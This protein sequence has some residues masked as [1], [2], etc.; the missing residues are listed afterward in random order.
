MRIRP[1]QH[2]LET[3][4]AVAEASFQDGEWSWGGRSGRNSISDAEQLLCIMAPA[5]KIPYFKIDVPDETAEDVL[6]SLRR[7]GDS[8]ELPRR[9]I[10]VLGDYF[11]TYTDEDGRPSFSA[12]SYLRTGE[13]DDGV[14][15]SPRQLH[16]DVVDSLSVSV[17]LCLAAIGFLKV[18]QGVIRR[19]ELRREV[20]EVERLASQRLSAAMVGLLRSFTVHTFDVDSKEGQILCQ[21]L[22]QNNQ[23]P[24]RVAEEFNQ[25]LQEVRARLRE[26]L[27]IGSGVDVGL[28]NPNLL[29]ECGWSWGIVKGAPEVSTTEPV[30]RQPEGFAQ[31]A[32]YLY[33]TVVALDNIQDLFSDRTRLLGLLNDEQ[34]RLAGA[35]QLRWELTQAY[36]STVASFGTSRWPLEDIPWRTTD[37]AESDY[38]T[39]L[40][41]SITV[42]ALS[43]EPGSDADLARVGQILEDLAGR[44]RITRRP[45]EKDDPGIAL[46]TPGVSLQLEGSELADGPKLFWTL[47]DFSPQLLK[48]T[49]RVAELAGTH[50]LRGRMLNLA[51]HIWEHLWL[52]RH[53]GGPA[54]NLWDQPAELYASVTP[55]SKEASWYYTERVIEGLV[56][57]ATLI[58]R[59]PLR[60][61]GVRGIASDMLD[62]AEHL[63]DRE[64]LIASTDS[65]P[66]LATALQ[67]AQTT[68]RRARDLLGE[69][70]STALVLASD[71]L[72]ELDRLSAARLSA[73][74]PM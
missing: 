36:W 25:R 7:I 14:T 31:S 45:F 69:R 1:R 46:H 61:H 21:M 32:P 62:E 40:V 17:Q 70:P 29:F 35:L 55:D 53:R 37:G 18:F 23:S 8:V 9:I 27:S 74:G 24:R 34:L 16:L 39:L 71:V 60:S 72:R 3:W 22:N 50:E 49:L 51:D 4:R 15:P 5:T 42:Q 63:L 68:L 43:K 44:A 11:R 47:S 41:T 65:G 67:R 58:D 48:R 59:P 13:E 38:F 33:F 12:G 66:A 26:E 28:E 20:E 52:R 6:R 54:E 19:E 30:H 57:A 10:R 64:M 56:Q 2:L 73:E